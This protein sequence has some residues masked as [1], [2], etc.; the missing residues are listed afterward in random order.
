M[1]GRNKVLRAAV[2]A[3]TA[4][5]HF[6]EHLPASLARTRSQAFLECADYRLIAD[7]T[8]VTKHKILTRST[9]EGAPLVSSADAIH[10]LIVITRYEDEAGEYLDARVQVVVDCDDGTTRNLD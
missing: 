1:A 6:R 9:S 7:V 2:E 10:E 5:F 3:A 8:N 4:L